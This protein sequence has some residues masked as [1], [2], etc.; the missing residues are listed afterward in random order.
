MYIW[1]KARVL[2]HKQ[3][4]SVLVRWGW[5]GQY[6]HNSRTLLHTLATPRPLSVKL[7]V[8]MLSEGLH[9]LTGVR[10]KFCTLW[11]K[12]INLHL[13]QNCA[14]VLIQCWNIL[15]NWLIRTCI[16]SH[17]NNVTLIIQAKGHIVPKRFLQLSH[18]T[19]TVV[20]NCG[21]YL[22]HKRILCIFK[23]NVFLFV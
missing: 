10:N 18:Q 7:W 16:I 14:A 22:I 4:S 8:P 17:K 11:F 19:H 9:Q 3:N 23:K 2:S 13:H 5:V 15:I 12:W 21:L 6:E 1:N 20:F